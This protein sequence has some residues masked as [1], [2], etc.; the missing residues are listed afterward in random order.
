[1][2]L[3]TLATT[4]LAEVDQ[5]ALDSLRQGFRNHPSDSNPT[6]LLWAAIGLLA[7]VM[8]L[9]RLVRLWMGGS[10]VKRA[11]YLGIAGRRLGLLGHEMHLLRQVAQRS[12]VPYPASMLLSP[13]CLAHTALAAYGGR[14]SPRIYLRLNELCLKLFQAPLPKTV[15]DT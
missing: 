10:T 12:R 9:D 14:L 11:N 4:T 2:T 13:A 3:W 5:T 15:D 7:L 8:L 1:M 6:S